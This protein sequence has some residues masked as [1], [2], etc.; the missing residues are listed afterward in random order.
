VKRVL[1]LAA[2]TML[3]SSSTATS[4]SAATCATPSTAAGWNALLAD[5]DTFLVGDGFAS[6]ARS[7]TVQYFAVG[8]HVGTSG[9]MHDNGLVAFECG[10]EGA[11]FR[12]VN[13]NGPIVPRQ[14]DGSRYWLGASVI[15]SGRLYV[16]APRTKATDGCG[17]E[18]CWTDLGTDLAV[19]DLP[20]GQDP[21][22]VKTRQWWSSGKTSTD[23][24]QWGASY[25]KQGA[26]INVFGHRNDA[27]P[28]TWGEQVYLARAPIG[29][30]G[31][32]TTWRFWN[33]RTFVTSEAEAAPVLRSTT[34]GGTES[35]FS[36]TVDAAGVWRIATKRGGTFSSDA[37]FF[38][39][40]TAAGPWTF[41][42]K[43]TIPFTDEDRTY[44]V[45][46]HTWMTAPAGKTMISVCHAGKAPLGLAGITYMIEH[47]DEFRPEFREWTLP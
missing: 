7:S 28:D 30:L 45:N 33:G 8:D 36:V 27:N 19:F 34:N 26:Y 23:A 31:G 14:S 24:V 40:P 41:V 3:L 38:T 11:R 17:G 20:A 29:K 43:D 6:I 9:K 15:D 25:V 35:A 37:G 22:Y 46:Q 4:A 5:S 16:T 18:W 13:L 44:I 10:P 32:F 1:F 12:L 47:P 42:S 2:F 39:G 21:R